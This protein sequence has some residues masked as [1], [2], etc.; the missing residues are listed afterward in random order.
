MSV[1]IPNKFWGLTGDS[2][3]RKKD[4]N[5]PNSSRTHPEAERKDAR[6]K[7]GPISP[8]KKQKVCIKKSLSFGNKNYNPKIRNYHPIH[9]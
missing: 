7:A 3:R 8:I 6:Q 1:P 4:A 2:L 9:D 5:I